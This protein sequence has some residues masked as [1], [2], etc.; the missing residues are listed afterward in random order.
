M[1]LIKNITE[2]F[3][4]SIVNN[5]KTAIAVPAVT[6]AVGII[7]IQSWLTVVSMLIGIVI[8]VVI[9]WHKLIQVKIAHVEHKEA[10]IR[11][12]RLEELTK[13]ANYGN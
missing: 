4:D 11:L 2:Q 1:S 12:E 10:K 7:S 5:Q 9:L 8:S 13:E 3:A 6:T